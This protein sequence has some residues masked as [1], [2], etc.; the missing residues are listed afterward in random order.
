MQKKKSPLFVIK[1]KFLRYMSA[2]GARYY[3]NKKNFS[4]VVTKSKSHR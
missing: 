4:Q 3:K 2:K 1:I